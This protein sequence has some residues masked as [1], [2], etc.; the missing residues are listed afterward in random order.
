[1]T[2]GTTRGNRYAFRL[3][4]GMRRG[5]TSETPLPTRLVSNEEFPP[6]PQTAA[7]RRVEETIL[8]EAGRLAP[9]LGLSRRDFLRTSGGV[10]TS[11]LAMNAVFGR[12]WDVQPVEAA[13]AAAF[14]ERSGDRFFIFD[15][16]LHY[17]GAGYDPRNE[18]ASRHGAVSKGALLGL[19]QGSRR[20]NPKLAS[21]RG[22][23]ADLAWANMVKEVFLD[24]ET[25]IGLI[26]TPP[27]PYP[28]EAVVP[29]KEMTHIRDEINRVTRSRRMLAHGLITPQLGQVDLDFMD[30][31]AAQMKVDAWKG[32]TGA[33]PKGFDRG[34]FVDDE[35]IAYPMLERARK[36]GIK[37]VCLHKGLPLGPVS[38]FTTRAT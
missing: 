35:K 8:A 20:L 22:T 33:A 3:S 14:K 2:T 34:W 17:V 37:R 30:Q 19:R 25:D 4:P 21:D 18:E 36:L 23:M 16:Q 28:Q 38:D 24:S 32:Y 1:M 13:D 29:P 10:A 5:V 11:L 31:Q 26:S 6:L 27:G 7:Q 9:R 15:V 12:F